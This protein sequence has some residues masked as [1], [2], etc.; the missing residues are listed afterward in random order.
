MQITLSPY[1]GDQPITASVAGDTLTVDGT[2]FDFGP[3]ADG[4]RLPAEATRSDHFTG[5]IERIDGTIHLTLRL[6]HGPA[7]PAATRFPHP[8]TAADGSVALPVYGSPPEPEE[9]EVPG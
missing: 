2:D 8:I 3:L 6:P 4:D 5:W 1:R 7:A 9:T